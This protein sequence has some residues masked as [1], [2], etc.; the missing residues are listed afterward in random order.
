MAINIQEILHPSDSDNIKF[1]KINY[2]FDQI[3]ANGGGPVGPKGLKGSQGVV[4][5]TGVKG[6]LG[7]QGIKGESGETTSPWKSIQI[8][9]DTTDGVDNV[10]FLKPKPDTD[11]ET[12][13]IW[14]GDSTFLNSGA[15][16]A[17]HG[18]TSVRSTLNIGRHYNFATNVID[19]EYMTL[20]HDVNNKI[21]LDSEDN[22]GHVR[23]NMSPVTP[24]GGS[25]PDVRFQINMA[26]TYTHNFRLDNLITT[27]T[28]DNGMIRYNSGGN[29]FEGYVNNTWTEFCMDPC[30]G[31]ADSISIT[32]GNLN[33]NADGTTV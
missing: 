15:L 2:N 6:E 5:S 26:A 28:F 8:D 1:S 23:Y 24:F 12:P 21:T 30:G 27:G 19:A 7:T 16:Q 10:T 32:V 4:G 11:L 20:W 9:L 14:L 3:L 25:A 29:K 18:D 31:G 13:I 22:A 33:L 17:D